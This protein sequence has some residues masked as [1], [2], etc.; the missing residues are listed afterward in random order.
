[1]LT[2]SADGRCTVA[3]APFEWRQDADGNWWQL[4]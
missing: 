2:E 4:R 1:M 3:A